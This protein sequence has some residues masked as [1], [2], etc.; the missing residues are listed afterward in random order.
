[1]SQ[2]TTSKIQMT[3]N[4]LENSIIN[5]NKLDE[6]YSEI[7]KLLLSALDELPNKVTSACKKDNYRYRKAQPF[8]NSELHI[9]WEDKCNKEK[10]LCNFKVETLQDLKQKTVLRLSFQQARRSFDRK[11]RYFF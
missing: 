3:I 5:Q 8:W 10:L 11:F 1:M 4:K 2:E 9:L 6:C 7:K